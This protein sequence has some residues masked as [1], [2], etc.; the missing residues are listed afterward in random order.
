MRTRLLWTPVLAACVLGGCSRVD[1]PDRLS[2]RVTVH[3]GLF[4]G[5]PKPDGEMALSDAPAAGQN[6]T[7]MDSQGRAH[8]VRTDARGTATMLL[9]PGAYTVFSTTCGAG[10][11][12]IE[13]TVGGSAHLQIVCAIP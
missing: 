1:L 2:A 8:V 12:R 10:R 13:L 3:I 6:V 7:A 9:P 11:Q 5:P 4:G